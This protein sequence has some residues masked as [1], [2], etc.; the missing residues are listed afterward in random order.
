MKTN[1]NTMKHM[2][3]CKWTLIETYAQ[4]MPNLIN[5]FVQCTRN[6]VAYDERVIDIDDGVCLWE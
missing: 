6:L 3:I 2:N 4:L 5:C 1:V